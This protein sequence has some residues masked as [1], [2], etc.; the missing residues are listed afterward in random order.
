MNFLM[1]ETFHDIHPQSDVTAVQTLNGVCTTLNGIMHE[2]GLDPRERKPRRR[3]VN[4][5]Y[6]QERITLNPLRVF[7]IRLAERNI[8]NG[9][10]A[11]YDAY[12]GHYYLQQSYGKVDPGTLFD[13]V[14][15]ETYQKK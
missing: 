9:M 14:L 11:L 3:A 8:L 7:W 13:E 6:M 1:P 2:K 5:Y 10:Y 4:E 15:A 12:L